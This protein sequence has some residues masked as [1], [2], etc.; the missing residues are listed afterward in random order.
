[1]SVKA[2]AYRHE[3]LIEL[4]QRVNA[5]SGVSQQIWQTVQEIINP[6]ERILSCY[7][8]L[9]MREEETEEGVEAFY[10]CELVLITT[11]AF[12]T[13]EFFPK[14][15]RYSLTKVYRISEIKVEN[16]IFKEDAFG[17]S[18][19][20]VKGLAQPRQFNMWVKFQDEYGRDV[21][22]WDIESTKPENVKNLIVIART[23]NRFVGMPLE[24]MQV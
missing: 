24:T 12:V 4:L 6:N 16:R 1:M 19:E 11:G 8:Q 20:P 22:T 21:F 14:I 17:K 9:E 2:A 23:L 15:Q 5:V 3:K 13:I 7:Y 10:S 18:T